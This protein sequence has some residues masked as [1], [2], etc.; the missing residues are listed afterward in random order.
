MLFIR[1]TVS[2]TP[3]PGYKL[4]YDANGG[5]DAPD[6]MLGQ[7]SYIV[8]GGSGM[9]PPVNTEFYWWNTAADGSGDIY[10]DGSTIY[11]TEDATLYAVWGDPRYTVTYDANGGDGDDVTQSGATTYTVIS[12]EG[13]IPAVGMVFVS[14][15][16]A[17][18]GSGDT[19][20]PEDSITP[21]ANTTLYAQWRQLVITF[22]ENTGD[23]VAPMYGSPVVL[24]Y[25]THEALEFASWNTEI[26]GTGTTYLP[27]V[28]YTFSGDTTLY[29]RWLSE[30]DP[31]DPPT[32]WVENRLADA[33]ETAIMELWT[34]TVWDVD[35]LAPEG[36]R[37]S[38]YMLID[39]SGIVSAEIHEL[40][41]PTGTSASLRTAQITVVM[42]EE[43][44]EADLSRQEFVRA[45]T[46]Y[47]NDILPIKRRFWLEVG[48][49][50]DGYRMAVRGGMYIVEKQTFNNDSMT[51]T[52][53]AIDLLSYFDVIY[54]HSV[55]Y[56]AGR[57]VEELLEDLFEYVGLASDA[58]DIPTA[59]SAYNVYVP[60]PRESCRDL[61]T[62]LCAACSYHVELDADG[63]IYIK[64]NPEIGT[65]N[66]VFLPEHNGGGFILELDNLP[67]FSF[68][69][70]MGE[71]KYPTPI[72][73]DLYT[74]FVSVE[75]GDIIAKV[76]GNSY[77]VVANTT[78]EDIVD[79]ETF[80]FSVGVGQSETFLVEHDAAYDMT[81]TVHDNGAVLVSQENYTYVSKIVVT[82]NAPETA[83]FT[84]RVVGKKIDI[85]EREKYYYVPTNA[86]GVAE[87]GYS[88]PVYLGKDFLVSAL[89]N[90]A[91][92]T[93]RPV[94]IVPMR[95]DPA[96]KVGD[97][98][99]LRDLPLIN[100]DLYYTL[101]EAKR[102]FNGSLMAEYTFI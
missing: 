102:S 65:W 64:E 23:P 73:E 4:T 34:S 93:N 39:E 41:D 12:A 75:N 20:N 51:F 76:A 100:D 46:D 57:S 27:G 1:N 101:I 13:I 97:T 80:V 15:N 10:E 24:P 14:W 98:V 89:T 72:N 82:R 67:F 28:E 62:K 56:P 44:R 22:D 92:V 32:S 7:E 42:P 91:E 50:I 53:D 31:Y 45:A 49:E 36:D 60:L 94:Y 99:Q 68:S 21:T 38:R 2:P 47:I 19:Y 61:I 66:Y 52:I 16:T 18:D 63:R 33:Q 29:A 5:S 69:P 88:N 87:M 71:A 55:Y 81:T 95:D 58:Y 84:V 37:E 90:L 3:S 48:Y 70:S 85:S 25:A 17:A 9:T 6:P 40:F 79:Y 78:T 83:N 30:I 96:L 59:L 11:L 54:D 26:D 86:Q 8:A 74:Q 35:P 43:L 77:S